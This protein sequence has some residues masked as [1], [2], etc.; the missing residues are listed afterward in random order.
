MMLCALQRSLM[1]ACG[2]LLW[3]GER[4]GADATKRVTFN[5]G[6][7]NEWEEDVYSEAEYDAWKNSYWGGKKMTHVPYPIKIIIAILIASH[8][9]IFVYWC[10]LCYTADNIPGWNP[11]VAVKA[12]AKGG[13]GY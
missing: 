9:G 12:K 11:P 10:Y 5:D 2:M 1:L 3:F 13:K 7:G 8:V 4:L 6:R